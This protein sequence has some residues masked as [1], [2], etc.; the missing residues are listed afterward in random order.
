MLKDFLKKFHLSENPDE[1]SQFD[2]T[3]GLARW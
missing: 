1:I 2:G 3:H